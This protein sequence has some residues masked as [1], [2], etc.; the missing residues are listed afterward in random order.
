MIRLRNVLQTQVR[1]VFVVMS[2][3]DADL[4]RRRP[5]RREEVSLSRINPSLHSSTFVKI[6][7]I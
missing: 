5:E 4:E 2:F 7:Y 3:A 6:G 1:E